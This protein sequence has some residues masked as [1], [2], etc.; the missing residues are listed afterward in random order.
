MFHWVRSSGVSEGQ[1]FV[2]YLNGL[3]VPTMGILQERWRKPGDRGGAL[4]SRLKQKG[5]DMSKYN[6]PNELYLYRR[7]D[8]PPQT[9]WTARTG[10]PDGLEAYLLTVG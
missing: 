10:S 3:A 7:L 1:I 6:K 2:Q 5:Q 9:V 8:A 4:G